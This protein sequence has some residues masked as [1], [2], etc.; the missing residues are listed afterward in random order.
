MWPIVEEVLKTEPPHDPSESG[1]SRF[2][3]RKDEDVWK[4]SDVLNEDQLEYLTTLISTQKMEPAVWEE[5][6]VSLAGHLPDAVEVIKDEKSGMLVPHCAVC[7]KA[8]WF[9]P[10][11]C[12]IRPEITTENNGWSLLLGQLLE[13]IERHG[14]TVTEVHVP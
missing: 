8:L 14:Q 5:L 7:K 10:Q 13:A 6:Y 2:L 11:K 4:A 1:R 9:H 3:R 12:K